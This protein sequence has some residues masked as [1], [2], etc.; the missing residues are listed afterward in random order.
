MIIVIIWSNFTIGK[1]A[2]RLPISLPCFLVVTLPWDNKSFESYLIFILF[3]SF[4]DK[5]IFVEEMINRKHTVVCFG[6]TIDFS[7]CAINV[8]FW[9]SQWWSWHCQGKTCRYL[10]SD[11]SH[12]YNPQNNVLWWCCA[13]D[14]DNKFH[15]PQEGLNCK[16]LTYEVVT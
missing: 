5:V 11:M 3:S 9:L 13:Q 16:S 8:R 10:L 6:M 12:L 1:L 4:R 15:W 7:G 2:T 14:L